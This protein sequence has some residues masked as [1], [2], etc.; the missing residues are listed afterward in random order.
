VRTE[1]AARCT[2]NG[3]AN[4]MRGILNDKD[5]RLP[6]KLAM[7]RS[8]WRKREHSQRG[9]LTSD[10][11]G[12][13]ARMTKTSY[14][15]ACAQVKREKRLPPYQPGEVRVTFEQPTSG[16]F[17]L[18]TEGVAYELDDE[19]SAL[20]PIRAA[21]QEVSE[22]KSP[23]QEQKTLPFVNLPDQVIS[24]KPI[25]TDGTT[26]LDL[27]SGEI[28]LGY[29]PKRKA[30]SPEGVTLRESWSTTP[31]YRQMKKG[32]QRKGT[33]NVTFSGGHGLYRKSGKEIIQDPEVRLEEK[34]FVQSSLVQAYP[35]IAETV[36]AARSVNLEQHVEEVHYTKKPS[37]VRKFTLLGAALLTAAAVVAFGWLYSR[38][39]SSREQTQPENIAE[40]N[41]LQENMDETLESLTYASLVPVNEATTD[42]RTLDNEAEEVNQQ[43]VTTPQE[44]F[45]EGTDVRYFPHNSVEGETAQSYT[46]LAEQLEELRSSYGA[47]NISEFMATRNGSVEFYIQAS[48]DP[49]GSRR[50]NQQLSHHRAQ[51][52]VQE[53]A[54]FCSE[55]NIPYTVETIAVG[56]SL[57]NQQFQEIIGDREQLRT[58]RSHLEGRKLARFDRLVQHYDTAVARGRSVRTQERILGRILRGMDTHPTMQHMRR[59]EIDFRIN[60]SVAEM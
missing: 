38:Y 37:R 49:R 29:I 55:Q 31:L 12:F 21:M 52:T 3:T 20:H 22:I 56:E 32:K 53:I 34:V 46:H 19:G 8:W 54:E 26:A 15:R 58:F 17:R 11:A 6:V 36:V 27:E 24:I 30:T 10:V 7:L 4:D 40:I 23:P 41:Q 50:A 14:E 35:T 47:E 43:S 33:R 39:N 18:H 59:A 57:S 16:M 9:H 60:Y 13:I 42:P 28:D 2:Q 44:Y 5:I 48:S 51:Q 25:K 1:R 45:E